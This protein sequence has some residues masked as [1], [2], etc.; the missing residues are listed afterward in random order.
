MQLFHTSPQE[1]EE[2]NQSGRFGE[3]LFFAGDVYV[4]TAGEHVVYTAE[5]GESDIIK[6][7]RLFYHD[8][9]E[10]LS[11]IVAALAE[12]LSI[13]ED[14]AESLIDESKSVWDMDI[15]V[16]PEDM[17]DL[18]W[19]IQALTARAAKTLGFKAVQVE[20]EQGIA[21]MIDATAIE[22]VKA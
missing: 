17:A 19:D 7:G 4:M 8:D 2:I 5:I 13:D 15:D 18:S 6:A 9:A 16:E 12:R 1:I 20:D 11:S 10:K 21:Y 3:F 14:D 22:M